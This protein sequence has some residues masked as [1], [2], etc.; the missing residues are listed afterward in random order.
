MNFTPEHVCI[1]ALIS[2]L[3]SQSLMWARERKDLYNRLQAGTLA[4]YKA[5]T[6][7][8]PPIKKHKPDLVR[9]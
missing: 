4:S 2:L 9:L 7:K 6:D 1:L 8:V 3:V 5:S